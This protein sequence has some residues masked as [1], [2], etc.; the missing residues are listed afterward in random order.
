MGTDVNLDNIGFS[1]TKVNL[2]YA[3]GNMTINDFELDEGLQIGGE[4]EYL[5]MTATTK[6]AIESGAFTISI[7]FEGDQ[8]QKVCDWTRKNGFHQML[9]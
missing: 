2:T 1:L 8:F 6:F 3:T 5:K 9:I 4:V 7:E